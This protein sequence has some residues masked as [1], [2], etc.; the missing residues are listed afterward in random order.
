MLWVHS[1]F[2]LSIR[3]GRPT[4]RMKILCARATWDRDFIGWCR[5]DVKPFR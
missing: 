2:T 1:F 3:V 5:R 4:F